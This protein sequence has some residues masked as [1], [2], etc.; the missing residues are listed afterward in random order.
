MNW[1]R[2][3]GREIP[4]VPQMLLEGVGLVLV[5]TKVRLRPEWIVFESVKSMIRYAP[6]NGTAGFAGRSS[7]GSA[8]GHARR[9]GGRSAWT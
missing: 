7:E 4:C 2:R 9:R 3:R 8:S 6:P 1:E 5:R